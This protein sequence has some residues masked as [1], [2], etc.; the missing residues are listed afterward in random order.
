MAPPK[1]KT[2][3]RVTPAG[4]RPADKTR[5]TSST[6]GAS[7]SDGGDAHRYDSGRYT[8]PQARALEESPSWVPILMLAL[9]A[10]GALAI[11]ARYLWWDSNIPMV[12]GMVCLLAGLFTATKWR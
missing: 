12:A 9:F 3:G 2:G 11:M 10:V 1:R 4:T 8:A 6:G 7:G 5:S